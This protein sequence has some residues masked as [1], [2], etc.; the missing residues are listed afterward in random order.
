MW[1]TAADS[2]VGF[3]PD[4]EVA[5][6]PKWVGT[7]MRAV[8]ARVQRA[9]RIVQGGNPSSPRV[10]RLNGAGTARSAIPTHFGIGIQSFTKIGT[11]PDGESSRMATERGRSK[12]GR[13]A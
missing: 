9:E 8:P 1:L 3:S 5:V 11:N 7:A 2:E 4:S 13:P 6:A 10:P 12:R